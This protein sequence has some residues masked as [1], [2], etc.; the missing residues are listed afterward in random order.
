[1]KTIIQIIVVFLLGIASISLKAQTEVYEIQLATYAAPEYKH[2]HKLYK[3][4]YVYTVAQN[5]GLSRVYM[6][7]FAE[8]STAKY[9]LSLVHKKGF[10]DAFLVKKSIAEQDA[11]YVVQLATY[12]Q[13]ADIYW[14]DWQRL[15]STLSVQLSDSK[16]RVCAGPY[17]SREEAAAVQYR[18]QQ[19]GPKDVFIKK[20]SRK[21]LHKVGQFD[22]QRSPSY[23]Q[24]TGQVRNSIK[25]LQGV[26]NTEGY[27]SA[28]ANGQLTSSTKAAII[29]YKKT[30]SRYLRSR[31]SAENMDFDK[32]PEIYTLQYYINMMGTNPTTAAAGLVQFKHPIAKVFLAYLYL[33]KDIRTENKTAKVNQLMNTAMG[34][35]FKNYRGKTRYDFSLKYSYEDLGQLLSHLKA[36][37]EVVKDKPA[38]PCWLLERHPRAT[39]KAFAPYWNNARDNYAIS[40]DCGSFMDLEEMQV[41]FQISKDFANKEKEISNF[42]VA[43]RWYINPQPLPHQEMESL[44]KWNGQLWRNLKTWSKAS[45]FQSKMYTLLRF[46]Y[47][48][49]LQKLESHFMSKGLAGIEARALGLK[50][51]KET[52]GCHLGEYCSET[53]R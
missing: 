39:Q 12:D 3:I 33:N 52:V 32:D 13:Q 46:S 24:Q 47:Y 1:M 18:I 44:E 48:D 15:S 49:A 8:R 25:A 6:G 34:Q 51:I 16:V 11:V 27:Y 20:V 50:L 2:F 40:T 35:V 29:K 26:L 53:A 4:G 28:K 36:M 10:K 45:T 41:L 38:M 19:R 31:A 43:N 42:M 14:A 5:N 30:N 21:V 17:Y 37:H 7:T 23:G 9:R 22:L